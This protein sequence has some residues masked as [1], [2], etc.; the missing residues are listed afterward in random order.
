[1]D[2]EVDLFMKTTS[3][4]QE[5]VSLHETLKG[6]DQTDIFSAQ[7]KFVTEEVFITYDLYLCTYLGRKHT[8]FQIIYFFCGSRDTF[9]S[10]SFKFQRIVILIART[11]ASS[12]SAA[13]VIVRNILQDLHVHN[14]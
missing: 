12:M 2:D 10:W 13:V 3:V 7:K 1:M 14:L 6:W 11:K 5:N 9:R 8:D 4:I